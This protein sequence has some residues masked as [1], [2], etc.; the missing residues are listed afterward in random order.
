MSGLGNGDLLPSFCM[1]H[2]CEEFPASERLVHKPAWEINNMQRVRARGRINVHTHAK[3]TQRISADSSAVHLFD[4]VAL[5]RPNNIYYLLL[6]VITIMNGGI[7]RKK[8]EFDLCLRRRVNFFRAR[9]CKWRYF[10][11]MTLHFHL[12]WKE[13]VVWKCECCMCVCE[14]AAALQFRT[15]FAFQKAPSLVLLTDWACE[16]FST[17]ILRQMRDEASFVQLCDRIK[18]ESAFNM[19]IKEMHTSLS[20]RICATKWFT[21][22]QSK[23]KKLPFLWALAN[24]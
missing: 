20:I 2:N 13:W 16:L 1:R 23:M 11:F 17:A 12:F 3:R 9:E 6:S 10:I 8:A 21:H 14:W 22:H 7:W 4:D 24:S 19:L 5:T 18:I 15:C